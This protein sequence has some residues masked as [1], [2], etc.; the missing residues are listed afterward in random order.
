MDKTVVIYV[1]VSD[2]S[3]VDN[4]SLDTQ[5]AA[6]RKKASDL[7]Y[8]NL[9]IFREEGIS[10]KT[11]EERP[12][13]QEA[14]L[15]CRNKKN[16]V[17]AFIVYSFSRLSRKTIDFLTIKG[18]FKKAGISLIS[19][20]EPSGDDPEND[21]ISTIISSIN[22]F[23]NE[24]KA[25][26][27]RTHM[28]ARFMQGYPLG[29][30][31]LGY[32]MGV[33]DSKPCPI[34]HEP[35]FSIFRSLWNR[36]A[37]NHLTLWEVQKELVKLGQKEYSINTLSDIFA[38]KFYM[39][40]IQSKYGEIKGKHQPMIDEIIYFRAREVLNGRK[41][42]ITIRHHF[43][44]DFPLRG[45]LICEFCGLKLTGGWSKGRLKHYPYYCCGSRGKHNIISINAVKTK[46]RYLTILSSLSPKPN[47]MQLFSE[48]V[49]EQY[50]SRVKQQKFITPDVS[51]DLDKLTF[52]RKELAK[53]HLTGIYTD[54][55]YVEL[56]NDLDNQI[57]KI[58]ALRSQK[59]IEKIDIQKVMKGVTAYFSCLDG[60]WLK[61][62]L[63]GKN[64]ISG[65]MFPKGVICMKE[66]LRTPY[67]A[68]IYE[69]TRDF[70]SKIYLSTPYLTIF[71][72]MI[73]LIGINYI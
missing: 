21:L 15:F 31:R 6:C 22:Q 65:S 59:A 48:M 54:S 66:E 1:R 23:D 67:I 64:K 73:Y 45:T 16:N 28:K 62:S 70:C 14:L 47:A 3:Q 43:R 5:E 18:Y 9:K 13:L 10:A 11:I 35:L 68:P 58:Y 52:M 39:G 41:P 51:G 27:V 63:E 29:K 36:I 49:V 46:E 40:I 34:P 24:I 17:K 30:A 61:A 32:V 8:S 7:G 69:Q 57:T 72:P 33:V 71:K 53:K 26:I 12:H 55:D 60:A 25:R 44:E 50:E 4:F 38:S 56:R 20:V 2:P 37:E 19:I 42:N